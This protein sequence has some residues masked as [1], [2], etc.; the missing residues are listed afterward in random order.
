MC[1]SVDGASFFWLNMGKNKGTLNTL[2]LVSYL[3]RREF[4]GDFCHL[5]L[6]SVRENISYV[7]TKNTSANHTYKQYAHCN[8][9]QFV[10]VSR[11]QI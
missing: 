3:M 11:S 7:H 6:L 9:Y 1:R 2:Y 8:I 4:P 5:K 10:I